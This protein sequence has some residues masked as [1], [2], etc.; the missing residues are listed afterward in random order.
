AVSA[1]VLAVACP[2]VGARSLT[3]PF[4]EE[5]V[6]RSHHHRRSRRSPQ[7]PH[8]EVLE[9]LC[10][11]STY[12]VTDLGSLGTDSA[13][14]AINDAGMVV[15]ESWSI[16]PSSDRPFLWDAA[17]GMQDLGTLGGPYASA[18]YGINSKGF[19]VG[20]AST[21]DPGAPRTPS[22]TTAAHLLTSVRSAARTVG[23]AAST[24]QVRRAVFPIP[25][26]RVADSTLSCRTPTTARAT[27]ARSA[28]T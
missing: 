15:G 16:A 22:C 8:L 23:H 24:M 9:S 7:P 21:P 14:Y 13:A 28:A 6:M 3:F 25:T 4:R 11:L 26:R 20:R 10:L 27:W 5:R 18:A 19:V 17:S 12:T 1:A 2:G